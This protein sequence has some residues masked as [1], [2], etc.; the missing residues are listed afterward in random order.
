M[1]PRTWGFPQGQIYARQG[2]ARYSK[3][4]NQRNMIMVIQRQFRKFIKNR[5]W[6]WYVIIRMT[7]P[8]IGVPNPEEELRILEE[9]ANERYGAY[10]EQLETKKK[11]EAENEIT[12]QEIAD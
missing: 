4:S 8:L 10:L 11:L 3:K 6:G 7:K 9:K 12:R 2:K 5:N 1:G